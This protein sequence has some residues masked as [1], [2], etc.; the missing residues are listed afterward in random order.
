MSSSKGTFREWS[1]SYDHYDSVD[2]DRREALFAL[3]NGFIVSRAAAP[4]STEDQV[5]YPGTYRVGCYNRLSTLIEGKEVENES[6]VNLPNWLPVSFR[7]AGGNW[8]SLEEADILAYRQELHMDKA[9]LERKVR[10]KS[11]EGMI[12]SLHEKRFVSM[13]QEHLMVLQQEISAENWSGTIEIRS[14]LDGAVQNNNVARYRPFNKRHLQTISTSR[15]GTECLGLI[16]RTVQSGIDITLQAR[17]RLLRQGQPLSCQRTVESDTDSIYESLL[18]ELKEGESVVVEKVAALYTSHDMAITD[19]REAAQKALS[20]A[21]D[22]EALL[23]AHCM[24]W[25]KLWHHCRLDLQPKDQLP[26]FRLHMFQILQNI[27]PHTAD[28]DVGVP[29]SGWQGEEYHGQIFWDEMFIFPFLAYRFPTIARSLLLYRYRRL[30]A[31]RKLA[32]QAGYRGAMYPWRSASSGREE[33]PLLQYNLYSGHWMEDFTYRQHHIGAI[34]A[35]SISNYVEV[36]G[37][38]SFFAEYGAEMLVETARFWASLAQYNPNTDRYEIRGVVGPDEHHTHYPDACTEVEEEMGIDNNSYTN[39]MAAWTLMR[40]GQMYHLLTEQQQLDLREKIRLSTDELEQWKKISSRIRLVFL[41]NGTLDQFEGFSDLQDFDMDA[42]RQKWGAQRI[43]WRLEAEGDDINRYKASKQA[44]TSLLLYLF[45]PVELQRIMQLMGY[46]ISLNQL[47][48]TIDNQIKHTANESSLSRIIHAGALAHFDPDASWKLFEKAQQI[49][50]SPL[51]DDD[52]S[53]GIHLGSMGGT[54]GVLQHHYA[55]IEV[56]E[57]TL[58]FN[59]SLPSAFKEVSL[60]LLFRGVKLECK[61][62]HMELCV[63]SIDKQAEVVQIRYDSSIHSLKGGN[64]F[65]FSLKKSAKYIS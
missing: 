39:V 27:S 42:F 22:F 29:P 17:T 59:P 35:Y 47:K 40:A 34:I 8:F 33:T 13:A 12:F 50:L 61:I 38:K 54:L 36:T 37:D 16:A 9:L 55:G 19:C 57:D 5:H 26:Y 45:T 56:Q 30:D 48:D 53:E 32:S 23:E 15:I 52:S 44:D 4:E 3:G 64:L 60:D 6:L 49:D 58:C 24:A 62:N 7:I 51:E 31:A 14:G 63:R 11:R 41:P 2:E 65:C 28:L 18:A 43:D 20:Q 25:K 46:D 1:I 21:Q 10:F